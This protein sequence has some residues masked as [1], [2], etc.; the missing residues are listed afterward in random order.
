[1]KCEKL[2]N[3]TISYRSLLLS[4]TI[5]NDNIMYG[6]GHFKL[7]TRMYHTRMFSIDFCV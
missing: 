6:T 7:D 4:T 3:H 5:L 1:M 2:G